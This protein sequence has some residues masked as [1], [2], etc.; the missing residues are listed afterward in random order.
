[1]AGYYLQ[2]IQEI[3]SEGPYYLGGYSIGGMIIYEIARQLVEQGKKVALLI[4]LDPTSISIDRKKQGLPKQ[5]FTLHSEYKK[6]KQ[7]GYFTFCLGMIYPI[8]TKFK[9]LLEQITIQTCFCFGKTLPPQLRWNYLLG[10]YKQAN[11]GYRPDQI[12]EGIE[13][14]VIIHANNREIEDWINLFNG[15]I[16]AYAIDSSHLQLI[17]TSH[18]FIWIKI[19]KQTI[20]ESLSK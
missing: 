6:L 5:K 15:K 11:L 18:A 19:I 12:P 7:I 2:M 3:D 20:Q 14:A 17:E 13:K 8:K 10:V 4:L 9:T 16:E 1:M